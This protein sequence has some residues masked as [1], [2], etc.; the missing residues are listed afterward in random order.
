MRAQAKGGRTLREKV[1]PTRKHSNASAIFDR[2]SLEATQCECHFSILAHCCVRLTLTV[3]D[4]FWNTRNDPSI[5]QLLRN[6]SQPESLC[7]VMIHK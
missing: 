2:W 5:A 1:Q 7:S 4:H 6:W 3:L